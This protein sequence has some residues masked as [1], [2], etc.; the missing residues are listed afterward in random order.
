MPYHGSLTIEQTGKVDTKDWHITSQKEEIDA[1]CSK[2]SFSQPYGIFHF[3]VLCFFLCLQSLDLICMVS[4]RCVYLVVGKSCS[5]ETKSFFGCKHNPRNFFWNPVQTRFPC[6]CRRQILF[7]LSNGHTAGA[8]FEVTRRSRRR[9]PLMR[10]SR[11][12]TS[13]R[14]G[15]DKEEGVV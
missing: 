8:K 1:E 11:N 12:Q 13:Q 15:W 10:S 14:T 9:E 4:Y 6:C 2:C 5:Y 3:S 7:P